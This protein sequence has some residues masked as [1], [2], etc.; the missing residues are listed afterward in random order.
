MK[1]LVLLAVCTFLLA[2]GCQNQEEGEPENDES[3]DITPGVPIS[4]GADGEVVE[5]VPEEAEEEPISQ[6]DFDTEVSLGGK[7]TIDDEKIVVEGESNLPEGT[8]VEAA[9]YSSPFTLRHIIG[10]GKE[11]A[12]VDSEGN[13][14]LEFPVPESVDQ[15]FIEI[16]LEVKMNYSQP[17]EVVEFFGEKGENMEGPFIYP[18]V[19][20][21]ETSYM[22]YAP[23]YV[24]VGEDGE[25]PIES[26]PLTEPP[27]DYGDT[28]V[29][30]DAEVDY[31]HD[32]IYVNGTSNLFGGTNVRAVYYSSEEAVLPQHWF[33]SNDLVRQDGSFHLRIPYDSITEVGF[34]ELSI[35]P[36]YSHQDPD[37]IYGTYGEDFASLEGEHVIDNEDGEGGVVLRLHPEFPEFDFNLPEDT[38]I[39]VEGDETKIQLP[40]NILFDFGESVLRDE[41]KEELQD[42]LASLEELEEGTVIQINGHT[43]NVGG[44]ELNQKLSEDRAAAVKAYLLENGD[45]DHLT[46]ETQGYG[47]SRPIASNDDEAGR[48]KNRR[49][50]FVINPQDE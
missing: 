36:D 2:S 23:V 25:Y 26:Q 22:V 44:E 46:I 40:D 48:Q 27:E 16:S 29:W 30:I 8:V 45:L 5:G 50:E 18:Y 14:T 21:G 6:E 1:R 42:F 39:T 34:V 9:R 43:D 20:M 35:W 10:F 41:A 12:N 3:S 37:K 31:D 13:F 11:F 32:F 38:L 28:E 47:F 15:A 7:V 4:V 24:L 17:D 19:D 49:V 33:S